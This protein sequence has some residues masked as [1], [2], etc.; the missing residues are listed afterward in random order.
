MNE[1]IANLLGLLLSDGSIY[2]DKSKKTYCIQFTNKSR[3]LRNLFKNLMEDCFGVTK[4]Y[5]IRCKNAVSIR[6]FSKAIAKMLF[7]YSP[8]FRTLPCKSFPICNKRSCFSDCKPLYKDG[9]EYP[10]CE[11]NKSVFANS[12]FKRSFI[13]GFVSGDGGVYIN[14]KHGIY[15]VEI[16]C[17]HPFL[18]K[19]IVECIESLGIQTRC[20][21][22]SVF[23]SG[24][25]PFTRFI[26][27][28]GVVK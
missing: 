19:Q 5:E 27:K 23:I 17:Y 18:K 22:R 2:F 6:V 12:V 16:V 20:K 4:F 13:R 24:I 9:I 1:E 14:K 3:K 21:R 11:I 10:P 8:T 15:T 25:T 7:Q 28:V 26:D